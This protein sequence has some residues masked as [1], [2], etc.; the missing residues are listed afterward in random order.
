[1]NDNPLDI[2]IVGPSVMISYWFKLKSRKFNT[3]CSNS[4]H[5]F[6]LFFETKKIEDVYSLATRVIV[7]S[8]YEIYFFLISYMNHLVSL[9]P[10]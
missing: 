8:A 3:G 1:M 10:Y 9:R 4:P 7:L 6:V 5:P 2:R